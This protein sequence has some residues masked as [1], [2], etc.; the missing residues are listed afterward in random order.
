VI[1]GATG[2]VVNNRKPYDEAVGKDL[3]AV[4]PECG[5]FPMIDDPAL[6][7]KEVNRLLGAAAKK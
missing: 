3:V 4:L 1:V 5:H 6:F 2:N 7:V